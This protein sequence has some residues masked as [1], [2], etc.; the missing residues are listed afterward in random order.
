[1]NEDPLLQ[2]N[3]ALVNFIDFHAGVPKNPVCFSFDWI[4]DKILVS[5]LTAP[6]MDNQELKDIKLSKILINREVGYWSREEMLDLLFRTLAKVNIHS[7][8]I[9]KDQQG[10]D[11]IYFYKEV[12][13]G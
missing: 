12:N 7:G 5:V 9:E 2:M 3:H 1:M 13:H 8:V 10:T 11:F 6:V 4:G